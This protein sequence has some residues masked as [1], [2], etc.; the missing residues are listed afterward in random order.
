MNYERIENFRSKGKTFLFN[1]NE[2]CCYGKKNECYVQLGKLDV[3]REP[4]QYGIGED[5]FCVTLAECFLRRGYEDWSNCVYISKHTCG[6]YS[7][8]DGQHRL[9]ISSKIN[10]PIIVYKKDSNDLCSV[11]EIEKKNRKMKF[12]NIFKIN[13]KELIKPRWYLQKL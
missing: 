8:T 9:C 4:R 6:H 5:M 10:I 7:V 11:C 12:L 2:Y 1:L 13:R 3:T